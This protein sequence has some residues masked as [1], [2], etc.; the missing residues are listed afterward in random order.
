MGFAFSREERVALI[1]A[2]PEKFFMPVPSDERYNWVRV[3]LAPL[4]EDEL[5][6]LVVGSWAMVVPKR[7]VADR[8]A[9][10][11]A[12]TARRDEP[13]ASVEEDGAGDD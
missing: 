10:L 9:Q 3:W 1:A 8:L 12:Q 5:T 13:A 7:L 11:E 6:E 2:E 4:G